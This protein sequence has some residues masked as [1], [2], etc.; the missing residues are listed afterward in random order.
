MVPVPSLEPKAEQPGSPNSEIFREISDQELLHRF[1]ARRDEDAFRLLVERHSS[2]VWSVSRRLLRQ[3][4]DAEDVFQAVFLILARKAGAIRKGEARVAGDWRAHPE[5]GAG[6]HLRLQLDKD[7]PVV[8]LTRLMYPYP[9]RP[10]PLYGEVGYDGDIFAAFRI[11]TLPNGNETGFSSG[12][13]VRAQ[14]P[15]GRLRLTRTGSLL[16]YFV[17]DGGLPY[18]EIKSEDIG[19]VD[20][21]SL[22]LFGFSGWGPVAVD[23]RFT[24]LVIRADDFPDGIPGP[25]DWSRATLPALLL[26][27]FILTAGVVAWLWLRHRRRVELQP[28]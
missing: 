19:N 28:V 15:R 24:D 13:K 3:E 26:A 23:V 27:G 21:A 4:Q 25:L 17:A 8:A 20:V 14:S 18:H 11:G 5:P 7:R 12:T 9:P 1:V 16:R 22:R 10:A 2:T 6:L